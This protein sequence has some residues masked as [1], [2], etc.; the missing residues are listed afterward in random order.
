MAKKLCEGGAKVVTLEAGREVP[1][2]EF[3]SHKWPYE[4]PY[5][6]FRGEKQAL[7]YQGDISKSIAHADRDDV[8]IDRVHVVPTTL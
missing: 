2:S 7:F 8:G 1:P 3:L 5:R 6:G 4:L